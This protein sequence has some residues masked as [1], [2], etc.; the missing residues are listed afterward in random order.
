MSRNGYLPAGVSHSDS[1]FYLPDNPPHD[2]ELCADG[3]ECGQ[4]AC[5]D[6]RRAAEIEDCEAQIAHGP[7]PCNASCI[8]SNRSEVCGAVLSVDPASSLGPAE[9]KTCEEIAVPEL[10]LCEK[11]FEKMQRELAEGSREGRIRE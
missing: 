4:E 3:E 10:G 5:A 8:R 1:Y 2:P 6:A 9:A 7:A 11:C